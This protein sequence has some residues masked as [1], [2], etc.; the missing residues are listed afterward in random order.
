[1]AVNRGS[2]ENPERGADLVTRE[3]TPPEE[4]APLRDPT[5]A[6]L[7]ALRD[8]IAAAKAGTPKDDAPHCGDC[9]ARGWKA[10][11]RAVEG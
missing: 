7:R 3:R 5:A 11:V 9:F 2:L 4:T 8:R 10:A 1:M 6:E